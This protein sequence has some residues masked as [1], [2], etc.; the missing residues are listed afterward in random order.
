M[1]TKVNTRIWLVIFA[2]MIISG[3]SCITRTVYAQISVSGSITDKKTGSPLAG[4]HISTGYGS[5]SAVSAIDG[6]FKFTG[7]KPGNTTIRASFIGYK[8]FNER[9]F[10]HRDT[11]FRI[12]LEPSPLLGDEVT[13]V[14]TRAHDKYPTAYS[15]ISN[16]E[17]KAANLGKD[18]P[19]LIQT[20]PSTVVTS[21]MLEM[22]WD[23]PASASV[24]RT[25]PA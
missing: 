2:A 6:K 21:P 25:S 9:V 14:A 22:V 20:S 8:T 1:C 4:A 23:I 10:L 19:T 16:R 3:L 18:I 24:E 17:I 11:T 7:V 15:S 5:L 13:I 12:E